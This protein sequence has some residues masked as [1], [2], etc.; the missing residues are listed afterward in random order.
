MLRGAAYKYGKH[1]R[2]E[3]FEITKEVLQAILRN[4]CLNHDDVNLYAAF[5]VAFAGFLRV[6]EF[7][8]SHWDSQSFLYK[9]S[10]GSIQ[11]IPDRVLL[12]LPASKI[13]P[14][15]K[16]ISIPLSTSGDSTC[17]VSALCCLFTHYPQ[18]ATAPLFSY[19]YSLFDRSWVLRK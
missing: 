7:T 15:Q 13:D 16:G 17:P 4:L 19:S 1:P 14:F 9:L 8:W 3:R 10:R 5:C 12:L 11:F 18:P 2:R 6:G